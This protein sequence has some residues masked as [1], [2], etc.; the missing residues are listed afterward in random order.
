MNLK[1]GLAAIAMRPSSEAFLK[2]VGS[3]KSI[4]LLLELGMLGKFT[5][6]FQI[7]H[8]LFSQSLS[9]KVSSFAAQ[10]NLSFMNIASNGLQT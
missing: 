1:V 6:L 7:M 8:V 2:S 9:W 10:S 3:S 4:R 5:N